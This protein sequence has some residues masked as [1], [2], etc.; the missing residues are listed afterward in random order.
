MQQNGKILKWWWQCCQILT[1]RS[2][3]R[4]HITLGGLR[5]LALL[6]FVSV[7]KPEIYQHVT[8]MISES[9]SPAEIGFQQPF[10]YFLCHSID[11]SD[12]HNVL[13]YLTL[14]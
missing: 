9:I 5:T 13:F 8:P 4:H 2:C 6:S 12:S 3:I 7:W 11:G 1:S 14:Y 10:Q